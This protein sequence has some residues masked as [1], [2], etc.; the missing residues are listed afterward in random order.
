MALLH[1]DF[2]VSFLDWHIM[3]SLKWGKV[4]VSLQK[5]M[6]LVL[7]FLGDIVTNTDNFKRVRGGPHNFPGAQN[8]VMSQ[9]HIYMNTKYVII[10]VYDTHTHTHTH[11]HAHSV[12][13]GQTC[14]R[15]AKCLVKVKAFLHCRSTFV[16]R[17]SC[18]D[19]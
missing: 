19:V 15:V 16:A 3:Q 4:I 9:K 10:V 7:N 5:L 2:F 12:P 17:F 1:E 14:S 11:T 6:P 13:L 18:N 8:L